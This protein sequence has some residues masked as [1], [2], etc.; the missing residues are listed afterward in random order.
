[1][2]EPTDELERRL[3]HAL[4]ELPLLR[5][6]ATLESRVLSELERRAALPWW[7][8]S[9]AHWP[10]PARAVFLLIGAALIR[11][12]FVGGSI[13]VTAVSSLQQSGAPP[14]TWMRQAEVLM[15][16]AANLAAL[17]VNMVPPLWLYAGFAVC[18]LL[19]AALFG[20]GAAVY[21]ALYL[22]PIPVR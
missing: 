8:R 6:P 11:L 3:D 13:A 18:A 20:L 1:M 9:F 2:N 21:H 15:T 14:L 7:R 16:S 5:A 19:Y 12:A 22:R 10:L 4:R 17:L